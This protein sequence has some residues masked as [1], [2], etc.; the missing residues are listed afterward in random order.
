LFS[1]LLQ[2]HLGMQILKFKI[3]LPLIVKLGK[4]R[5][6]LFSKIKNKWKDWQEFVWH[7]GSFGHWLMP[8]QYYLPFEKKRINKL[9]DRAIIEA[10]QEGAQVICLGALNKVCH[11]YNQCFFSKR[12]CCFSNKK[13]GNFG[14][15]SVNLTSFSKFFSWFFYLKKYDLWNRNNPQRFRALESL[16][17]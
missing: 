5:K 9:I 3:F 10:E 11:Y 15:C 1:T 7:C 8:M 6:N 4:P 12:N 13:L 2:N 17:P 16:P 14:F